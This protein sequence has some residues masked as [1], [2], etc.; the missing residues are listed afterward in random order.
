MMNYWMV[1][2]KKLAYA[3]E[4]G[5]RQAIGIY[6][7]E[8]GETL[9]HLGD[10]PSAESHLREALIHIKGGT[11]YQYAYRLC[12]LGEILL[13]QG[14]I[15][16]SREIFQESID[17]MK[18]GEKWGQGKVLAG[19]SMA[20]LQTGNR[21]KA[22]EYI[23]QAVQHH[24]DGHTHYFTHF[25]LAAYAYLLSQ[26]TDIRTAIE[27]YA[28]LHQQNFIRGSCWFNNLYRKPIYA[29]AMEKKPG[30]IKIAEAMGKEMKL[31]ETL[32]QIIQQ[33]KV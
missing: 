11:P 5:D 21:D 18:I 25:S 12:G 22:W 1:R 16:E 29:M 31:W 9:G 32:E 23:Q 7:A 14:Q 8:V 17:G 6:L 4:R 30:E 13:V 3:R 2:E 20:A 15:A 33:V 24:Y 26:Q 27:I 10:Y 19:L 28:M